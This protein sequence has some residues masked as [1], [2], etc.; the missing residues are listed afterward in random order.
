MKYSYS[1][2]F[3][4]WERLFSLARMI[5]FLLWLVFFVGISNAWSYPLKD[6]TFNNCNWEE[7]SMELPLIKNADYF[8]YRY[9]P[10]YRRVYSML[11]LGTYFERRD[12]GMG[13]HQGVDIATISGT[14][15]YAS[16]QG[17]VIIADRRGDRG[18]VV[19]IKHEWNNQI[20]Y[21][22]YAHL[23]SIDVTLGDTIEEGEKLWEVGETGNATGPHLHFQIEINQDGN[24]PFFPKGCGGTI[25]EIVNEGT[26]FDQVR[27][28]TIDP[29]YFLEVSTKLSTT[30]QEKSST[31]I[32]LKNNDIKLSG[33]LGWFM[34]VNS[35]THLS[36]SK[37]HSSWGDF[38]SY[39]ISVSINS[40]YLSASP[41]QITVLERERNIFLQSSAETGLTLVTIKYGDEVLYRFP[42]LIN[43]KEGIEKRK[44][45]EKLLIALQALG[46]EA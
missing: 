10:T 16:Y 34:E 17:E 20:V 5:I 13:S 4:F 25:D 9:N 15:V 30:T 42:V 33:F 36:F 38:L 19:V 6:I 39:P 11:R 45:N 43:D 35:S 32:Y 28:S 37:D 22:T 29:I 40:Q 3:L 8:S 2:N 12:V 14:P 31:S 27:K 24:H 41:S 46:I 18:N 1:E 23:S 21:T 7:C 26:C 44:Q